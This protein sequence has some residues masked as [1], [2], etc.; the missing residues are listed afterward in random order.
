MTIQLPFGVI[1]IL[2]GLAVFLMVEG[3][4]IVGTPNNRLSIQTQGVAIIIVGFAIP[5][6]MI[7]LDQ[8]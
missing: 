2:L 3:L 7:F 4:K 6:A 1:L 5:V 8:F